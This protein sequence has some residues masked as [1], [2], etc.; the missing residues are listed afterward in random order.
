M[1]ASASSNPHLTLCET[2]SRLAAVRTRHL[3]CATDGSEL[4]KHATNLTGPQARHAEIHAPPSSNF[5]VLCNSAAGWSDASGSRVRQ[6]CR[7]Q[8]GP[9]TQSGDL[10]SRRNRPL[11]RGTSRPNLRQP[12]SG[13]RSVRPAVRIAYLATVYFRGTCW[14]LAGRILRRVGPEWLR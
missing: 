6:R 5:P 2:V 4:E 8:A 10:L 14:H 1:T 12:Q 13:R 9:S 7:H 3:R 11:E